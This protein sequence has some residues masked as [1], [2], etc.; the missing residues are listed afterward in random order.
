M[1]V[2]F[3]LYNSV[4]SISIS[5][6]TTTTGTHIRPW[7]GILK[8]ALPVAKWLA[9]KQQKSKL[10]AFDVAELVG[11]QV[12][13]RRVC[14]RVPTTLENIL[15]KSP[16]SDQLYQLEW[17]MTQMTHAR[18]AAI[19]F[20][21]WHLKHTF[22]FKKLRSLH[23]GQFLSS[24]SRDFAAIDISKVLAPRQSLLVSFRKARKN[25]EKAFDTATRM[26]GPYTMR[27]TPYTI[28]AYTYIH[29]LA[30]CCIS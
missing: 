28:I 4:Q 11:H 6:Q 19:G 3:I 15:S 27:H 25:E 24:G 21:V 14:K 17:Q 23:D 29:Y 13:L 8:T 2:E 7:D 20:G 26:C 5:I 1:S 22:R 30:L 9:M 10:L 18:P 12:D 16:C